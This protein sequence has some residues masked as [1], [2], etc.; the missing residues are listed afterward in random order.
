MKKTNLVLGGVLLV[1]LGGSALFAILGSDDTKGRSEVSQ[2]GADSGAGESLSPADLT[3]ANGVAAAPRSVPE[4]M[5][6]KTG[7]D[8]AELAAPE[9]ELE[10]PVLQGTVV[11]ADG[12]TIAGADVWLSKTGGRNDNMGMGMGMPSRKKRGEGDDWAKTD[13]RGRFALERGRRRAGLVDIEVWADGFQVLYD[14]REV[15]LDDEDEDVGVFTLTSGVILAGVVQDAEGKPVEGAKIVSGKEA[16][17]AFA[18]VAQFVSMFTGSMNIYRTDA[19]GRFELPNEAP[20]RY[21]L[22]VTHDLFP[23]NTFEGDTPAAGSAVTDLVLQLGP[24]AHIEGVIA[25]F[26]EGRE[27]ILVQALVADIVETTDAMV[28][29]ELYGTMFGSTPSGEV[30]TEGAFAIYG[31]EPGHRYEL[32]AIES[33]GM[34]G[35]TTCSDPVVVEAPSTAAELVWDAGATITLRVRDAKTSGPVRDVS[36]REDWSEG[37]LTEEVPDMFRKKEVYADGDVELTELR[38]PTNRATL[39]LTI[40]APGYYDEV[41]EDITVPTGDELDLGVVRMGKA[42]VLRVQVLDEAT[43]EPVAKARVTLLAAEGDSAMEKAIMAMAGEGER[44]SG[45]TDAEGRCELPIPAAETATFTVKRSKYAPWVV[46]DY[47]LSSTDTT[48]TVRLIEGGEVEVH[49]VDLLGEI[50]SGVSIRHRRPDGS[51]GTKKS[52]GKPIRLSNLVPGEH[53]FRVAR[54]SEVTTGGFNMQIAFDDEDEDDDELWER[55]VVHNGKTVDVFLAAPG[56]ATLQGRVRLAGRPLVDA[57]VSVLPAET[58]AE[59]LF[60]A[61]IQKEYLG[62]MGLARTPRTGQNGEY[63]VLDA[64]IGEVRLRIKHDDLAIPHHVSA[65]LFEGDNEVDVDIRATGVEGVVTDEG[66]APLS[67]VRVRVIRVAR[68][69]L[70]EALVELETENPFSVSG[71]E[72]HT[73]GPDGSFRILGVPPD[74]EFKVVAEAPAWIEQRSEPLKASE[75]ETVRGVQLALQPAGSLHVQIIGNAP[76]LTVLRARFDGEADPWP[77]SEGALVRNN[78]AFFEGLYPGPWRISVVGSEDGPKEVVEIIAG[79][80]AY[81]ALEL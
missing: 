64:P 54:P 39:D 14:T 20:G 29:D 65:E 57:Q 1:A 71:A 12:R 48:A 27:G 36:V 72:P 47:A 32:R 8:E 62:A 53:A 35:H 43:G 74:T 81:L 41:L 15:A 6:A 38:P 28:V 33:E 42:P 55:V 16:A 4:R 51:L 79:A 59:E 23:E 49:V 80:Q 25:G 56:K 69:E 50:V 2:A 13:E 24:A 37:G 68:G 52:K 78:E 40:S 10:G 61:E 75:G 73:T 18:E 60:V 26:P 67:G 31:L 21:F 70:E 9:P 77:D 3:P 22:T 17:G 30:S 58:E 46:D 34:F 7:A 45:K 5:V 44:S 66:G 11:D 76:T 19:E 63:K